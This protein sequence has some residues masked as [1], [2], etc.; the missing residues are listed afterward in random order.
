MTFKI[1]PYNMGSETGRALAAALN[2]IRIR[3][4]SSRYV[5]RAGHVVI[6]LGVAT[7][8]RN[9]HPARV[10]NNFEAVNRAGNKLLCFQSFEETRAVPWTTSRGQ[11]EQWLNEDMRPVCVRSTLR[12]YGGEGLVVLEPGQTGVDIPQAPLYT[13][14]VPKAEEY[15]VH[16]MSGRVIDVQ[17][18]ILRTDNPPDQP[19]FRVRNHANGFIYVRDT[20]RP[21]PD[22]CRQALLAIRE[23]GLDFGAVDIIWNRHHEAAYVLEINTSPGMTGTTLTKY[24][25]AFQEN[26]GA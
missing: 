5:P 26:Y 6:N 3:R 9:F 15:R 8:P 10:V 24:V 22:V 25:E 21:H 19:N 20:A 23:V 1:L 17:K 11:A 14:Y 2:C 12:G 18:K 16:V 7:A 13:K 4:E